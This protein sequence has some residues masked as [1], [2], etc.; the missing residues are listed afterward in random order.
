MVQECDRTNKAGPT[1][2]ARVAILTLGATRSTS[3]TLQKTQIRAG[4]SLVKEENVVRV[5]DQNSRIHYG[6]PT[7][8][9]PRM[10]L[11]REFSSS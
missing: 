6:H 8:Q 2:S 10:M 1:S 9:G 4:S 3:R 5:Q 11:V 7:A